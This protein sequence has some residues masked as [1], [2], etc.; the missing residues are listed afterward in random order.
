[1]KKNIRKI[2]VAALLITNCIA[3]NAQQ[4]YNGV[5][6]P[7][8]SWIKPAEQKYRSAICINGSWQF[9]P[10]ALPNGFKEG[11]DNAPA[12]SMPVNDAW[13]KTS[14]RIPSPWNINSF[15]D[16][17]GLGGDFRSYPSYPKTW[18]S[19]KMGWLRRKVSVPQ[20]W[21]GQRITLHFEA[22]AGD[23]VILINGKNAGKHFGIFLP[24][25]IDVTDALNYGSEN[26]ILIGV[27]KASLFDKRSDYGRRT[28]QAGSF[29]GQHIAGIWQDV[30]LVA[31]PQV[32]IQDVYV[33]A[34]LDENKLSATV[35]V[36]NDN[37]SDISV[38]LSGNITGW[39]NGKA[40]LSM[41][42]VTVTV[43]AH[44]SKAVEL[45]QTV[46][47]ALK[48]WTPASPELYNIDIQLNSNGNITDTKTTRFGWRQIALRGSQFLLNGKPFV[49]KGDSWHFMGIPQMTRRY[50]Q[51]WYQAMR[52]ANL[53]AVRLHA[54]P[55]PSFYLD[56]ADEM[57]ILVLDESAMWASDG[58]PK[59]GA[60]EY[61][62]DS[63]TH[64]EELVKRDRNHPSVFGWSISNEIKPIV[65]GVMRNP[66]GMMDTL[67]AHYAKWA[68]ICKTNDPS[69]P[70]ISA[71]GEDDGEGKLP[72]YIVHYGG[73]EA[74]NRAAK[75]GK[76]WGVGEA[77]NAYYGT[78]E[79]VSETN[80]NRAYE[81][82]LGRME[83]V[84]AS[85]YQSLAAQKEK[86]AIYRSVFN[87]VWYG[88]KPLP[89]GM[90][91]T[92]KPPAIT[93]GIFFTSY[94]ENEPGVQPERLGPYTT[95]LN[96]G[97]DPRLPLYQT[98]PLF[99]AIKDAA[100]DKPVDVNKWKNTAIA[101]AATPAPVTPATSVGVLSVTSS[102]FATQLKK[103][104]VR[105]DAGK[106]ATPAILFV[107][108]AQP[109]S[110]AATI[111][112][113]VY[114]NG[115]TVIVW[116]LDSIASQAFYQLLPGELA[117]T[118]RVATS[119][120]PANADVV[121]TGISN[122]DLYFSE[123]RPA[124]ITTRGLT[125]KLV[126]QSKVLLEA[127]NTDWMLWN[128]Q[129]EYAKTAMVVR[130]EREAKPSGVVMISK[131][132]GKGRLIITTLPVAPR[133]AKAEKT[134]RRIL[135]NI[136]VPLG[137]GSDTI[138]PV[139]KD[140]IVNNALLLG[141]FPA[142]SLTVAADSNW[143]NINN[144]DAIKAYAKLGDKQWNVT[145]AENGVFVFT[146][147][148]V[149]GPVANA[150]AYLSYWIFSPRPLDDLLIEP[151]IPVVNLE[152]SAD[153]AAQAW[154]NGKRII[155]YIRQGSLDG[156]VKAEALKLHQGWNHVLVKVINVGGAWKCAMKLTC[157]QP[158][159]LKELQSS[160][161]KP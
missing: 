120:L 138:K 1:M 106:S 2:I 47:G 66:P 110:D 16:K 134:I 62:R 127:C 42:P 13:D 38:K 128:K 40:A 133:Q 136:G 82:F 104:G 12:L 153:D 6:A 36:R 154:L 131:Q 43:P 56:V 129:P 53:N 32:H 28:Y 55:Y 121:T 44:A 26:E 71:D 80:G 75:S 74:M 130:S 95:T 30:Y 14:I 67:I 24:F 143:I 89:L 152:L 19:I 17:N 64:M 125:G 150:A 8:D 60:S 31:V 77:G 142:S 118:N 7:T 76:P 85:S 115:G 92:T 70:W 94:K 54:Q 61:W 145:T 96:P 34:K 27:R 5:F 122:A 114:A 69:R 157:N 23:A 20:S 140:G 149:N 11:I 117:L 139:N 58:G 147:D 29:W 15:A 137:S 108:A 57:G 156:K 73:T 132:I 161:E 159:F 45:V 9:Q 124:E 65:R 78:P 88:L 155:Q 63:E 46:G 91:D 101:N 160:L 87:L 18:E 84:A 68:E 4:K 79:Q 107:D 123:Q 93:D 49:M 148:K 86:D 135:E 109:G 105:V 116:G 83:G 25:D 51:A 146:K 100:S 35:M 33:Q 141:S 50:A 90:K 144:G 22:L 97:Y 119:L 102:S 103:I 3:T 99:D 126:K 111:M 113:Q 10:V 37:S 39:K 72:T 52:D 21:K 112:Q 81:S 48:E 41:Q 158:E 59:L 98:W 151:N